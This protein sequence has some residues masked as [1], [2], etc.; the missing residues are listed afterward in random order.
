MKLIHKIVL[1]MILFSYIPCSI[2]M[3]SSSA[4]ASSASAMQ[5]LSDQDYR[6]SIHNI[7]LRLI[8]RVHSQDQAI[9]TLTK[10][11]EI[12]EAFK[13]DILN[14][15]ENVDASIVDITNE[16]YRQSK[17]LVRIENAINSLQR[18][19]TRLSD[20]SDNLSS[21]II[22]TFKEQIK[23]T[24][25]RQAIG[26]KVLRS[27]VNQQ[28]LDLEM[29]SDKVDHHEQFD[30][31]ARKAFCEI[32]DRFKD[33]TKKINHIATNFNDQAIILDHHSEKLE[34]LAINHAIAKNE[35]ENPGSQL[36]DFDINDW[37]FLGTNESSL[38]FGSNTSNS[39]SSLQNDNIVNF[40]SSKKRLRNEEIKN[41][42]NKK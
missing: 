12:H 7:L 19:V 30:E 35:L 25:D 17:V 20:A 21:T 22:N 11:L 4:S 39:S 14:K 31:K 42:S 24:V 3:D 29:I 6:I 38:S 33:H 34:D 8:N 2:G 41:A 15:M 26:L 32:A 40:T 13:Q 36:C 27:Q 1:V 9:A 23:N 28:A 18:P 16:S 37:D 10:K 5:D